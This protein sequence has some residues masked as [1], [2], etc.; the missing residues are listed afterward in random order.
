MEQVARPATKQFQPFDWRALE[1][2]CN[3][4]TWWCNDATALA[5]YANMMMMMMCQNE[6]Q[7][8][9]MEP[10]DGIVLYRA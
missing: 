4:W 3:P 5:G 2:C 9:Q 1:A 8:S 7:L 10:R 6:Y